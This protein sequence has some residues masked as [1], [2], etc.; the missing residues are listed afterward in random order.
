MPEFLRFS[1]QTDGAYGDHPKFCANHLRGV[2]WK[3][4]TGGFTY[5]QQGRHPGPVQ[6]DDRRVH[7][8][9]AGGGAGR[10]IG[11]RQVRLHDGI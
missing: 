3:R 8:E 11:L 5:G 4:R 2:E 6:G 10:R 9:G 7:G 1:V